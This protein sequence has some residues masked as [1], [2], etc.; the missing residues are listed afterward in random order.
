M[1]RFKK[2]FFLLNFGG[3][4]AKWS[5]ERPKVPPICTQLGPR[6]ARKPFNS[7]L[8]DETRSQHLRVIW[9]QTNATKIL[10]SPPLIVAPPPKLGPRPAENDFRQCLN[11]RNRSKRLRV[12][13]AQRNRQLVDRSCRNSRFYRPCREPL[14]CGIERYI[15]DHTKPATPVD[16]TM[17][18]QIGPHFQDQGAK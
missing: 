18:G 11:D 1:Q 17:F 5:H 10:G 7:F 13:W 12:M 3:Y 9:T 2:S 8:N 14:R 15:Q 6:P 4:R 16:A